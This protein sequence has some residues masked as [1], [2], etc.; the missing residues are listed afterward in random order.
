MQGPSCGLGCCCPLHGRLAHRKG[1]DKALAEGLQGEASL[2]GDGRFQICSSRT[3][4]GS[5]GSAE[6]LAQRF[7]SV[8]RFDGKRSQFPS[9][10]GLVCDLAAPVHLCPHLLSMT[11]SLRLPPSMRSGPLPHLSPWGAGSGQ[12]PC[13]SSRGRGLACAAHGLF[14]VV[15]KKV[16]PGRGLSVLQRCRWRLPAASARHQDLTLGVLTAAGAPTPALGDPGEEALPTRVTKTPW[17]GNGLS[18][19]EGHACPETPQGGRSRDPTRVPAFSRRHPPGPAV[20]GTVTS[21]GGGA[22]RRGFPGPPRGGP[23]PGPDEMEDPPRNMTGSEGFAPGNVKAVPLW[24][25]GWGR[26]QVLHGLKEGVAARKGGLLAS[27]VPA[28]GPGLP[29]SCSQ[30]T[31]K[32]LMVNSCPPARPPQ[33]TNRLQVGSGLARGL[34]ALRRRGCGERPALSRAR[35]LGHAP[36]C[37]PLGLQCPRGVPS[38]QVRLLRVQPVKVETDGWPPEQGHRLASDQ[39]VVHRRGQRWSRAGARCWR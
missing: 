17:D 21:L 34:E 23:G 38:A 37:L 12:Q 4:C 29:G 11:P 15:A 33:G 35:L 30:S 16:T 36:P 6:L 31:P 20:C 5:P 3:V 32:F 19:M 18:L 13:A 22:Q 24:I 26:E 2:R 14:L 9:P 39:C 25:S 1:V 10:P 28:A 7:K 8:E 27:Q